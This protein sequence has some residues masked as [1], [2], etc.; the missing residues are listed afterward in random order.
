M[1][2]RVF[3]AL[4][5]VS[6]TNYGKNYFTVGTDTTLVHQIGPINSTPFPPTQT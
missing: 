3:T 1:A 5:Y 2:V 4:A 6:T